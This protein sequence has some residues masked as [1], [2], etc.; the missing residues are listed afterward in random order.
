MIELIDLEAY[1]DE[2]LDINAFQDYCPNGLQ[3]DAGRSEVRKIVTGVTACQA[4]IDA[5]VE[6]K[7]DLILV[8]HGYF[9]KG[10]SEPL[11]G[12]KGRRIR[13]LM[14]SGINLLAYH[15]P[16]DAHP[17]FGNNRQLADK[18]GFS[19]PAPVKDGL[20]WQADLKQP[21]RACELQDRIAKALGQQ[22]MLIP[23]GEKPIRRVGWCSGGAQD[24]IESAAELGLDAYI[25]GEISERTVHLTRELGIH[26][27]AAGHHATEKFGVQALGMHLADC[28]KLEHQFIDIPNPA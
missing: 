3:V 23:I 10:E 25:T 14:Q 18:L 6:V 22:P 4:L 15:L 17:E 28:H 24:Y 20:M 12:I 27:Y 11:K 16:L 5:A 13:T 9:W 8:H 1:C 2:L 19:A 21:L 26:F 7:A